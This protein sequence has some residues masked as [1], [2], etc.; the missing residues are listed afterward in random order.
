M[1]ES[2]H[3][4]CLQSRL[5]CLRQQLTQISLSSITSLCSDQYRS[6]FWP[7]AIYA[8]VKHEAVPHLHRSASGV[9]EP[10]DI[11]NVDWPNLWRSSPPNRS[12]RWNNSQVQLS[13]F[14]LSPVR[15]RSILIRIW[16]H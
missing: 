9:V 7:I 15:S 6:C 16:P 14:R 3:E 8:H 4:P 12:F 1:Q 2:A 10:S 13:E 5:S 11:A